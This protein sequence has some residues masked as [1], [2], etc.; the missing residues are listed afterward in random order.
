MSNKKYEKRLRRL[1]PR[2][3][4]RL[5]GFTDDFK[6]VV[7]DTQMYKQAGNSIVV[8]VL[9][10]LLS[11]MNLKEFLTEDERRQFVKTYRSSGNNI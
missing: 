5:M 2:E 8:D 1:T 6:I 4:L 9:I 3:C 10:A 11:Q 7:S